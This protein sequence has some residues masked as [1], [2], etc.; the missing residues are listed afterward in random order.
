MGDTTGRPTAPGNL[1]ADGSPPQSD[2]TAAL[3]V[4]GA[5]PPD[6]TWK[7]CD[8]GNG[9]KLG[10]WYK[11]TGGNTGANDGSWS[12]NVG[13]GAKTIAI[14]LS[15]AD[16]FNPNNGPNSQGYRITNVVAQD[17]NGTAATDVTIVNRSNPRRWL[18]RDTDL[19]AESGEYYVV[20]SY[21]DG[22][23]GVASNIHCDPGW[24]NKGGG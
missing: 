5:S 16:G 21:S 6:T 15:C 1:S 9:A 12:F 22:H 7:Q 19:D 8:D 24:Q 10:F 18:L 14:E 13:G 2:A 17:A 3:N 20:V 4:T 11:F 23:G